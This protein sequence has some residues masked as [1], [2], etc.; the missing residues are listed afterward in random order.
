MEPVISAN[1]DIITKQLGYSNWEEVVANE[2]HSKI[3]EMFE[4]ITL[5]GGA[6]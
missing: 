2:E 6:K 4:T 1:K 3:L 5:E